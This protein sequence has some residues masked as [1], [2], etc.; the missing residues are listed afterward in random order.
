MPTSMPTSNRDA[1]RS[2]RRRAAPIATLALA[3]GVAVAPAAAQFGGD[4]GMAQAFRQDFYRRDLVLFNEVLGLEEWQRPIVEVLLD[5]YAAGFDAGMSGFRERIARVRTEGGELDGQ[6]IMARMMEPLGGWEVEKLRLRDTFLDNVRSQLSP[7]Q[8]ERWSTFMRALRRD[9][10]LPE[11]EIS[12]EGVD[13][14]A[15][16]RQ[17]Q[18]APATL[19]AA[20]AAIEEYEILLDDALVARTRRMRSLQP[21][22]REAMQTMDFQRGLQVMNQIMAARIEVRNAQDRGLAL[23]E[24][25]L[26]HR[27]GLRFREEAL[28]RSYPKVYGPN[29]TIAFI[30]SVK[31]IATLTPAQLGAIETIEVGYLGQLEAMNDRLRELHRAEE[32]REPQRRFERITARQRGEATSRAATGEP[33]SIRDA[34]TEREVLGR[35]TREAILAILTPEQ[36]ERLPGFGGGRRDAES[37]FDAAPRMPG[38]V[39]ASELGRVRTEDERRRDALAPRAPG[40]RP[41]EGVF[42]S[43]APSELSPPSSQREGR[44]TPSKQAPP[45]RTPKGTSP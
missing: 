16:L 13:L 38:E 25:A 10:D 40:P 8:A 1:S 24:A 6:Q 30:A 42:E 19:L 12:G 33:Q 45:N 36:A 9:K 14:T 35:T 23:I 32:P 28:R 34:R 18:L 3:I 41:A 17:L 29:P 43:V 4:A 22:V 31:A 5:D 2:P 20:E 11:S 44:D 37:G 7:S 39:D 21:E 15:V 27:E 26:P